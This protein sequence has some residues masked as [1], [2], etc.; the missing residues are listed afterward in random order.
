MS[1]VEDMPK[2]TYKAKFIKTEELYNPVY[3]AFDE[4]G[5]MRELKIFSGGKTEDVNPD[6]Y[7]IIYV[8]DQPSEEEL[9]KTVEENKERKEKFR[10][11]K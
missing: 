1:K 3:M 11:G 9:E 2:V 8:Y 10:I 5:K 4:N 6:D 7:E